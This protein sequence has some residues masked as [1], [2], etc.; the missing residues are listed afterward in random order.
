IDR[1]RAA[2]C[3][4]CSSHALLSV[5][6][7]VGDVFRLPSGG[8]VLGRFNIAIKG[9]ER[10]ARSYLSQRHDD[11]E[12]DGAEARDGA[13]DEQLAQRRAHGQ[14][15]A[16]RHEHGV[17]RRARHLVCDGNLIG[18][19]PRLNWCRSPLQHLETSTSPDFPNY[20]PRPSPIL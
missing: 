18:N 11:G 10:P 1:Q 5:A 19:L 12:H 8:H 9:N 6:M 20:V 17:L 7:F 4:T 2:F 16:V 14:Q 13:V 3:S 15:R